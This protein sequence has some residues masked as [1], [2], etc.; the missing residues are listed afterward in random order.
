LADGGKMTVAICLK[1][2]EKRFALCQEFFRTHKSFLIN[3][4][5]IE[6]YDVR[7]DEVF[8]EMKNGYRIEV[9][10]RKKM[11]LKKRMNELPII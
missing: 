9:S 10:R 11:A 2:L 1:K 6:N 3:L 7:R 4:N 8:V 5:Y